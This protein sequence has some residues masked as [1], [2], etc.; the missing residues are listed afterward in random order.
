MAI[1]SSKKV[2]SIQ[3]TGGNVKEIMDFSRVA[4]DPNNDTMFI[5]KN[6]GGSFELPVGDYLIKHGDQIYHCPKN[7][8]EGF[9]SVLADFEN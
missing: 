9:V 2:T 1:K 5:P 3:F 6:E 7:L 4:Y 8:Y